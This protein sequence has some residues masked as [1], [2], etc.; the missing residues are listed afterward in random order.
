MSEKTTEFQVALPRLI[1]TRQLCQ[2]TNMGRT[3]AVEFARS[4]GAEKRFGRR[5][6]YDLRILDKAI[7]AKNQN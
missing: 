4:I 5:C 2:Y 6:L 7:D 3:R 1:S